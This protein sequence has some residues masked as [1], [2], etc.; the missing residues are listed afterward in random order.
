MF[1]GVEYWNKF[2]DAWSQARQSDV[3]DIDEVTEW[4]YE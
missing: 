3:F 2:K 1:W 4:W